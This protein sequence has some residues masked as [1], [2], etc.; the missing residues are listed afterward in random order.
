MHIVIG[1][2]KWYYHNMKTKL[3]ALIVAGLALGAFAAK[4]AKTKPV[5]HS[6]QTEAREFTG[7]N[8]KVFRYRWG[9]KKAPEGVKVPV[10][11]FLHGAGERGTNNVSQLVH[12]V[13]PLL[14]WLDSHEKG[15]KLFA[16]QV[17]GGQR[18]V[19]VHWGAKNHTMPEQPSETMANALELLDNILKMPD[20]DHD[21]VYVT[22]ISMGGFGTWD[23]IARRPEL[24]AA[25]LPICGGGDPATAPRIA[26]IPIWTFHGSSDA[27]VRVSRSRDMM[28]ALWAAGS[29]AHYREYPD[30]GHGIW[31]WVYNDKDVLKWFFRQNRAK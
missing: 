14:K 20:V 13:K 9:E 24:F 16:G 19:E 11:I 22:G 30:T 12:G 3:I 10:V 6:P 21:R 7:S 26:H 25:A 23:M 18:W 31:G 2:Q 5:R 29:N 15:Y 4:P 17:P 27:A 8:G 28:S 1:V